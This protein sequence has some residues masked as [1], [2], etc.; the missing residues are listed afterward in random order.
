MMREP[1]G[2]GYL[3]SSNE[4]YLEAIYQ[5]GG[6]GKTVRSVDLAEKLDVSKASVNK[7]INNLKSAG[8]VEQPHYGDISLTKEGFLYARE[9][10]SRHD[11]LSQFLTEVLGIEFEQAQEEACMMEHAI[12]NE[13]LARWIAFMEDWRSK[14][15]S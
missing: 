3:S 2:A 4:D 8:L 13:T 6:S 7:A 11:T 14:N 15:N 5:L 9:V 12:S 10:Q 1:V